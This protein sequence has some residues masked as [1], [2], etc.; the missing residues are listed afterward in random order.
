MRDMEQTK[1]VQHENVRLKAISWKKIMEVA[2]WGTL[3]W[4]ILRITFYFFNFTPYGIQAFSRPILG[5]VAENSYSGIGIGFGILFAF[6]IGATALFSYLFASRK[7]WWLGILYGLA[8]LFLFGL[9]FRMQNWKLDT[10]S[11]E[12]AWFISFGLFI[13]MSITAER[14]DEE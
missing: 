2:F 13:G 6:V 12:L 7:I 10:L 14:I 5:V 11:T 9:F 3:I 4:G 8:F 1:Q